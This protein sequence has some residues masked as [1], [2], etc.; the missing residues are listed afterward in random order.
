[1]RGKGTRSDG[2]GGGSLS[3]VRHAET[4][5]RLVLHRSAV[6]NRQPGKFSLLW[7]RLLV[8]PLSTPNNV[9]PS[10]PPP[11][12]CDCSFVALYNDVDN[13]ARYRRGTER[14]AICQ[15]K[16]NSNFRNCIAAYVIISLDLGMCCCLSCSWEKIRFRVCKLLLSINRLCI[17][18]YLDIVKVRSLKSISR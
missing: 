1:M 16:I 18:L 8:L 12:I 4:Y 9:P 10:P 7:S 13:S 11:F 3:R 15:V 14:V 6:T 17:M 2:A 5:L